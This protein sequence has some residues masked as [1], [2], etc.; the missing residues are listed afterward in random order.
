MNAKPE[1]PNTDAL[2]LKE[3]QSLIETITEQTKEEKSGFWTHCTGCYE[4]GEYGGME[5]HYPNS[6]IFGGCKMGSGCG[7]CGGLGVRWDDTDYEEMARE[8]L[9]DETRT[10]KP[11]V[12]VEEIA[13]VISKTVGRYPRVNCDHPT[14]NKPD[15]AFS[16][17]L[18]EVLGGELVK[19]IGEFAAQAILTALHVSRKEG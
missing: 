3:A 6:A 15:K 2:L 16:N 9:A 8:I 1:E 7:E 12:T 10:P 13:G 19:E 5:S 18:N 11:S 17:G 14:I 4:S